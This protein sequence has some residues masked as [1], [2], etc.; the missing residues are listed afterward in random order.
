MIPTGPKSAG[1]RQAF[2]GVGA[3]LGD[4]WATIRTALAALAREPGLSG[5]E[6]SAVYETAPVGVRDQPPFLNL[7]VGVETTLTPEAL[8]AVLQETERAAGRRREREVRWGPRP[9]DLDL[10]LFEGE[11]RTGAD[12]VLPHPRMWERAFVLVPLRELFERAERF[13][14]P[15][16]ADVRTR[17]AGAADGPGVERW[18]PPPG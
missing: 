17:L 11:T 9:L 7:V 4:R 6:E 8:L 3:N 16:W 1:T 12:V 14:R 13:Q 5:L 2:I 10:L 18:R 15:A